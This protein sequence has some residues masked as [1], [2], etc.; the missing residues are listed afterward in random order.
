MKNENEFVTTD[1]YLA[2][3]L[4]VTREMTMRQ[5]SSTQLMFVFE[6]DDTIEQDAMQFTSYA[7]SVVPLQYADILRNLKA[8]CGAM[9]RKTERK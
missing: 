6:K 4:S 2:A 5:V 1:M 7:G 8:Q 3:Y 9:K